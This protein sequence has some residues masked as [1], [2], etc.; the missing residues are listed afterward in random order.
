MQE[1]PSSSSFIPKR[2]NAPAVRQRRKN[3]FLLLSI[4]SYACLIAA[5]TAAAAV[6]VYGIYT[7]RQFAQ[8]V[9]TLDKAMSG[10]S[11][12]DLARVLEF[13]NRLQKVSMLMD[14]HSTLGP[15][16][17]TLEDTTLENVSFQNLSLKKIDTTKVEITAGLTAP[18][19]DAAMFQ[20][21]EYSGAENLANSVLSEITFVPATDATT[22]EQVTMQGVFTFDAGKFA[23]SPSLTVE[24][25]ETTTATTSPAEAEAVITDTNSDTI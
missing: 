6:Y 15:I 20:R 8:A 3:S 13:D 22:E 2:T 1:V 21:G 11:Q 5:P 9:D 12:A 10:F 18:D 14:T 19:F 16:L 24:V 17:K 25:D 4:V 23:Y 7:D